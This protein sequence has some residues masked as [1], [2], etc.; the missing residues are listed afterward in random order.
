MPPHQRLTDEIAESAALYAL[1]VL[2]ESERSALD[3]HLEEGCFICQSEISH[4]G[5][6]LALWAQQTP[7]SP[8]SS[9]RQKILEIIREKPTSPAN[10]HTPVLLNKSGLTVVRTTEMEWKPGPTPGLWIKVLFDDAEH[11]MTTTLVRVG[12]G[13]RYPSHRHKNVEE[14]FILEGELQ[15]EGIELAVGDFCLS[16]PNTVHQGSYSKSGCLLVVKT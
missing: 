15:V 4:F 5:N 10:T 14:L 8:P 11:D 13:A 6:L 3:Q 7:L 16:Q 2:S 1:G 9:L 12:P